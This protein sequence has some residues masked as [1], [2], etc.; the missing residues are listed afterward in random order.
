MNLDDMNTAD[1]AA[2]Y[3]KLTPEKL[4]QLARAR[5]IGYVKAGRSYL[6]SREAIQEWVRRN[7]LEAKPETPNPWGLTDRALKR[8]RDGNSRVNRGF[9]R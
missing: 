2:E 1:Q 6:F 4:K 7:S 9:P 8:Q 3:L 5:E